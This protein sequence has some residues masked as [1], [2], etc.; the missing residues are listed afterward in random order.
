MFRLSVIRLSHNLKIFC[1]L[2]TWFIRQQALPTIG[3]VK[4]K[5]THT[6][7]QVLGLKLIP[8]YRQ[9]TRR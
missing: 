2:G 9:S 8:V 7:F 3:E 5:F 4:V 1:K 6:T